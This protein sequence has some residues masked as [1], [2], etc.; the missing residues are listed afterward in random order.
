VALC[1]RQHRQRSLFNAH[2]LIRRSR[3]FNMDPTLFEE[4]GNRGDALVED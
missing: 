1:K 4:E 3:N 2:E